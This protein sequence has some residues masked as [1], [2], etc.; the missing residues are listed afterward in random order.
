MSPDR[1][2]DMVVII[3]CDVLAARRLYQAARDD[4]VAG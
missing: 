1:S 2:V 4:L 3:P